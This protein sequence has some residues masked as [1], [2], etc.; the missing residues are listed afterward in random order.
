MHVLLA[1]IVGDVRPRSP[2]L[3]VDPRLLDHE[4]LPEARHDALDLVV[5]VWPRIADA[6]RIGQPLSSVTSDE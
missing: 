6:H 1:E 4:R 5:G 2:A 3:R